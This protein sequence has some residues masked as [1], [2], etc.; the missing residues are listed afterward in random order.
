MPSDLKRYQTSGNTHFI[1]FSCY[2]R[3]PL[4]NN[5]QARRTFENVLE[6]ARARH[7]FDV[8]GY[9][10]MPEHVHL[11][12]SEP[13]HSSLATAISVLKAATSKRI[14]REYKQFWQTRYHDFNVLTTKKHGE[15]L[16]YLHRNPVVRELVQNPEDWPWS[17]FCHYLTGE[18]G[19]VQI[20]SHW[21]R[22]RQ[23][24]ATAS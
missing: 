1:T 23:H 12:L 2:Q 16:R 19:T 3:R 11:L 6:V 13:E 24:P 14:P 22:E 18:P 15:K 7:G 8:Y 5:D 21:T 20:A 9:V 17:S 10:L 4:L